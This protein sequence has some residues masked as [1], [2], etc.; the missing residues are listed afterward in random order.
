[1]SIFRAKNGP[2]MSH[3]WPVFR[4]RSQVGRKICGFFGWK[5]GRFG[6]D[7]TSSNQVWRSRAAARDWTPPMSQ[8]F[9]PQNSGV[10]EVSRAPKKFEHRRFGPAFAFAKAGMKVALLQKRNWMGLDRIC[11]ANPVWKLASLAI[12]HRRCLKLQTSNFRSGRKFEVCNFKHLRFGP[13]FA[14][15]KSRFGSAD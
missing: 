12:G 14:K 11:V 10:A 15:A 1:M 4:C 8:L 6:P 9:C 13:A 7:L 5:N 3:F 2:K